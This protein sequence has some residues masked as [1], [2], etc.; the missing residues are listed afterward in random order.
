MLEQYD[1]LNSTVLSEEITPSELTPWVNRWS[2]M[3]KELGKNFGNALGQLWGIAVS[4]FVL[5]SRVLR[6]RA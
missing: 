3:I 1:I 2:M 6:R 5:A 4:P